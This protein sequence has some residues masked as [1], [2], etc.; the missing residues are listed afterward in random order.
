MYAANDDSL[1]LPELPRLSIVSDLD[2]DN[3]SGP[4]DSPTQN[5]PLAKVPKP[6]LNSLM[7]KRKEKFP[8]LQITDMGDEA[9]NFMDD[10]RVRGVEIQR[11]SRRQCL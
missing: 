10:Q 6:P 3:T 5:R 8:V 1:L 11:P 2:E 9:E 4:D 7:K